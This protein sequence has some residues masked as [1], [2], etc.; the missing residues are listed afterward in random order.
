MSFFNRDRYRKK[1]QELLSRADDEAFF[2][3]IWAIDALQSDRVDAAARYIQFPAAA[4]TS[5]LDLQFAIHKWDMETLIVQLLVTPKSKP[6][7]G[8]QRF[9]NCALFRAGVAAVNY[10]R[11][12]GN[13]ESGIYLK[14]Y[15]VLS[16]MHRIGYR[17]FPWQHGFLDGVELYRYAYIYGRG[18]CGDYFARTYGLTINQFSLIS[19]ALHAIFQHQPGL[20]RPYSVEELGITPALFEAA[21]TRLATPIVEA[22]H[23]AAKMVRAVNAKHGTPL[24]TC[25]QPSLLRR[26][27]IV[28]FGGGDRRLRAPLPELIIL[29]ATSGVYYDLIAGGAHLRNEA[30]SRFEQY[31]A[32]YIGAMIPRLTVGRSL[33][34]RF[35]GNTIDTPNI[36]VRD[37]GTVVLAVECKTTKLTFDAQF[38][39]DPVAEAKVAHDEIAKGIF[40]LWRYFSHTRRGISIADAVSADA[41][42]MVLTLDTW[43]VMTQELEE[44]LVAAAATLAQKDQGITAEDRRKVVFCSIQGLES[45]LANSDEDGFLRTLCASHEDRFAGWLLPNVHRE[46]NNDN[47]V[48]PKLYPFDLGDVLPWWSQFEDMQRQQPGLHARVSAE[49]D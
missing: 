21:L 39:E 26:F 5:D 35:G 3:M 34:Y 47:P 19:F 15:S 32:D 30:G 8:P 9:T 27:P 1:L 23:E 24:P 46:I 28:S 12:L 25:Y 45:M 33:K 37:G 38:A 40:Q 20:L 31:S 17:Q 48:Q 18:E 4:A 11:E 36:L 42:G 43:L 49:A 22:R 16:E 29:R 10:L 14:R 6:R 44:Q 41:H 13:A 2:Q 7:E